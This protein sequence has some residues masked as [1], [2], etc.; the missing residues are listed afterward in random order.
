MMLF[1]SL[2]TLLNSFSP[3]VKIENAWVRPAA[4]GMNSALYFNINNVTT[5]ADALYKVTSKVSELVQLHTT[6]KKDDGTAGMKE[7]KQIAV[8][9]NSVIKFEPGG[10]HVM[11]I[12]LKKKLKVNSKIEFIFYFKTGGKV[13]VKATVRTE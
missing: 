10:Y 9:A 4:K 2:L 3:Q 7:I 13:K 5:K 1:L 8:P 11:L 6:V 12:N